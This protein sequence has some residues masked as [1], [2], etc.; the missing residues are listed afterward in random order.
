MQIT[1]KQSPWQVLFRVRNR[2]YVLS[3]VVL[4]VLGV[5]H[6]RGFEAEGSGLE[7]LTVLQEQAFNSSML[8]STQLSS[9]KGLGSGQLE[10]RPGQAAKS[11][12]CT[13]KLMRLSFAARL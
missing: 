7:I 10:N 1:R 3:F 11:V 13:R 8:T 4:V 2:K 5:V 6:L 9:D 12:V